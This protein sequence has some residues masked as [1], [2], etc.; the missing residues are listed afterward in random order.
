MFAR[1]AR[2]RTPSD[3]FVPEAR[4]VLQF[5]CESDLHTF[6][7]DFVAGTSGEGECPKRETVIKISDRTTSATQPMCA[8]RVGRGGRFVW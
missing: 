8:P 6:Y 5:T 4:F 2:S 1:R 3:I 7:D